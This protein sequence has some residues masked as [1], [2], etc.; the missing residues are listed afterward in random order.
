MST[1]PP[2]R[3]RSPPS[4]MSARPTSQTTTTPD[5]DE[6]DEP[7]PERRRPRVGSGAA[8]TSPGRRS[9]AAGYVP[10]AGRTGRAA[11]R[12]HL[13]H[14]GSPGLPGRRRP[15]LSRRG[16]VAALGAVPA[17]GRLP[18]DRGRQR[19]DRRL[20]GDR[21][22]ARRDRRPRAAARLRRRRARRP[23]G[24]DGR[25]SSASATPTARWTPPSCPASLDPVRAG[26]GRPRARP[27]PSGPGRLAG[28]RPRRQRRARPDAARAAPGCGCTTSGRCAPPA[29]RRCSGSGSPT[30]GSATRWRWSPA[31]PTPAGGSQEVDVDYGLRTAGS[32]SKVTGTVLGHGAHRPR[33]ARRC[34]PDEPHPGA[35]DHEGAGARPQQ[36]P[37]DPAV[38]A[39][40][41]PPGSPRRRSATPSTRC[42]RPRW[43]AGS[44][45]WTAPPAT[46]TSTASRVVPQVD[47]DL[48]TR[49]AA[50]FADAMA[51]G[52]VP[53]LLIG[54]D[55]PQVTPGLLVRCASTAGVGR[56]RARRCSGRRR[57]AAG[58]RSGCT[59][60]SRPRCSRPCRCPATTPPSA[61]GRRWRRPG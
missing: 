55:T 48:G 45:R 36:D 33:H 43:P 5:R 12:E 24:R 27:A 3:C 57:T 28:A 58:G 29:A 59:P 47:G 49:L 11:G 23:G 61:P 60:R 14:D 53:T 52:P 22:R 21:R 40:S 46:S 37:A 31:P 41:R 39:R 8:A 56:P 7:D 2:R 1:T 19:V 32:R 34:W 6:D 10:A 16:R 30:G 15:P 25:R 13:L 50:A 44:S 42:G 54:M 38:H 17:A 26:H 4:R 51:D 9:S 20:G 18:G 35:G